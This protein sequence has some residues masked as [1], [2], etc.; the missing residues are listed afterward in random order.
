MPGKNIETSDD[1][2][3]YGPVRRVASGVNFAEEI[4][5]QFQ[6]SSGLEERKFFENWQNSIYDENTWNMN[7]Y[8]DYIG[9]LSIFIL[10]ILA[11]LNALEIN[12]S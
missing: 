6:A 1:I 7:Y 8:N 3:I 11:G 4:N 10:D 5:I 12:N 2:N 9:T